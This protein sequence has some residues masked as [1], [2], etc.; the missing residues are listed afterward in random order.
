MIT[1]I[2]LSTEINLGDGYAERL[3]DGDDLKSPARTPMWVDEIR[4]TIRGDEGDSGPF[5][6]RNNGA[7][8]IDLEMTFAGEKLNPVRAPL[9][10]T[11]APR[12]RLSGVRLNMTAPA[13]TDPSTAERQTWRFA[14]PLFVE[15]RQSFGGRVIKY[16]AAGSTAG[17]FGA[18][19][20]FVNAQL[21]IDVVG[22]ALASGTPAPRELD[23]PFA[24]GYRGPIWDATQARVATDQTGD[25][26]LANPFTTALAIDYLGA[27][28]IL[29]KSDVG[30][31]VTDPSTAAFRPAPMALANGVGLR[32]SDSF[33]NG[34]IR[35]SVPL[36]LAVP[37]TK[38]AWRM[39]TVL[40]PRSF[41]IGYLD[42]NT[43]A[44]LSG[45][46]NF[47]GNAQIQLALVGHRKIAL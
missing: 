19:P 45:E 20:D 41:F 47:V 36:S 16:G 2:I 35:D 8:I 5:Q 33:G 22:R 26:E 15:P 7:S 23:L 27:R 28:A 38:R 13:A 46:D 11:C 34:I 1:P 25:D 17:N 21:R 14:K 6:S 10:P 31:D 29:A 40:P 3:I 12:D 18:G 32:L 44:L 9:L 24:S 42:V 39:K 4:F 43:P 30:G 37:W